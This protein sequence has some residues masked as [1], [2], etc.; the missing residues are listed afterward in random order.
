MNLEKCYIGYSNAGNPDWFKLMCKTLF[1]IYYYDNI[2]KNNWTGIGPRKNKLK[3]IIEKL[4][5]KNAKILLKYN[6]FDTD[7]QFV[8][9]DLMKDCKNRY[10]PILE[11][12][13][14]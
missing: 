6:I 9:F 7:T 2:L 13:N 8:N 10:I 3:R 1:K 12:W 14:K 5:T 11:I 4:K